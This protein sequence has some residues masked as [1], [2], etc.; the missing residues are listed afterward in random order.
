M[1]SIRGLATLLALVAL[2]PQ[3]AAAQMGRPFRNSWFWGVK[4]GEQ[5]YSTT[6]DLS[7]ASN[8]QLS[9]NVG[10]DWLITRN[11]GGLYFSFEQGFLDKPNALATVY[12]PVGD[13]LYAIDTV[14]LNLKNTRR[15]D[16]AGVFSPASELLA[17][18]LY[19]GAGI[20]FLQVAST[21]YSSSV[22]PSMMTP[23]VEEAVKQARTNVGPVL[24]LGAQTR[25]PMFSVFAQGSL[26]SARRDFILAGSASTY[27]AVAAGIR[28][29]IG[30]AIERDVP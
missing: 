29:N 12:I 13:N 3:V 7:S 1:R 17:T 20:S 28:Y 24:L 16:I 4:V 10:L 26:T 19:F 15:V 18:R 25:L 2:V 14:R 5:T 21:T 6:T 9:P 27:F 8:N 30:T 11:R 22:D 23:S